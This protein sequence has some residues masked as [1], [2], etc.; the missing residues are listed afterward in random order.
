MECLAK[1][2][3]HRLILAKKM[4][5]DAMFYF[6][7]SAHTLATSLSDRR[8]RETVV[9]M[10]PGADVDVAVREFNA[11]RGILELEAMDEHVERLN[12]YINIIPQY[13][14][15]AKIKLLKDML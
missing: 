9:A 8:L 6:V 15:P 7:T 5:P 14:D 13:D 1:L 12:T 4:N 11:V 10:C 2:L 3:R